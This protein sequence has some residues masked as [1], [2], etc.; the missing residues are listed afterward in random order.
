MSIPEEM[1]NQI[2]QRVSLLS[3]MMNSGAIA[4][5]VEHLNTPVLLVMNKGNHDLLVEHKQLMKTRKQAI[6]FGFNGK[7]VILSRKMAIAVV[8]EEMK[9][10][11]LMG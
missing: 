3:E 11:G 1:K 4:T 9:V 7:V 5:P 2:A 10:R 8:R 6:Q